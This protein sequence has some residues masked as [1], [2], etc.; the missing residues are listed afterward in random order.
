MQSNLTSVVIP[1]YQDLEN[2]GL[3]LDLLERQTVGRDAF[4]IIISDNSSPV[5]IAAIEAVIR[6]R[7]KLVI[8][9]V[10]GAGYTRNVGVEATRGDILAFM[11]SDCRPDPNYLEAGLA[12][13][14]N[15]DVVGG[16][17]RVDTARPGHP[18]AAEAFEL[19]FAFRNKGY[20]QKK[21]FTVTASLF[22]SRAIFD[23]VGPFRNDVSEDKEWCLR[24]HG[25]G[26]RLG[27]ADKAVIGHPAR[28]DWQELQRKWRRITKESFLLF[29]T[30]KF[31][32]LKWLGY[33]WVVLLA[34][35][36]QTLNVLRSKDV[37][38]LNNKA[39]AL[40]MLV[41][42]RVMRLLWS[43]QAIFSQWAKGRAE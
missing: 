30:K 27:Y 23:K 26:Y 35:I 14:G 19:V 10:K 24:A 9:T 13:L 6:G 36:P 20:I 39:L 1:H 17:V 37:P 22:V 4:E 34:V 32:L 33:S 12:A 41:R 21:H 29:R 18:T 16:R 40:G 31:G 11:D 43:H 38:G 42:L 15:Y 28:H 2:L 7:A 25:L 5:G 3:C 8:S